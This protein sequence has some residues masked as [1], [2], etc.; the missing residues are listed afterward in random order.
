METH[1]R[2][3][4]DKNDKTGIITEFSKDQV[5]CSPIPGDSPCLICGSSMKLNVIDPCRCFG[6]CF[7]CAKDLASVPKAKCP[8]C[9]SEVKKI[10]TLFGI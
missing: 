10:Y 2:F 6:L 1:P 9:N 8:L 5:D 7:N 3:I 4:V